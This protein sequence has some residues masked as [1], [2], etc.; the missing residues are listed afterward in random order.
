MAQLK[1][2]GNELE[3]KPEA[4]ET[5]NVDDEKLG[6]ED[7]LPSEFKDS[8][9][10]SEDGKEELELSEMIVCDEVA[11]DSDEVYILLILLFLILV[12]MYELH[13]VS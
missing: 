3:D 2:I 12:I 6:Y 4:M 9:N 7:N 5:K 1:I 8:Q 11:G 10:N 13:Q